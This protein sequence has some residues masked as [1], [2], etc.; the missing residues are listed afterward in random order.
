MYLLK[1]YKLSNVNKQD[2]LKFSLG[3]LS[4]KIKN[5]CQVTNYHIV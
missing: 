2:L 4:K 3:T 1:L 5:T